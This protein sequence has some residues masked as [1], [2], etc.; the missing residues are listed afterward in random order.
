MS[1]TEQDFIRDFCPLCTIK[2][3]ENAI[4]CNLCGNN[5]LIPNPYPELDDKWLKREFDTI[6]E[7]DNVDFLL[8][9]EEEDLIIG[10]IP[11]QSGITKIEEAP[12]I[13]LDENAVQALMTKPFG[14]LT[15]NA[16]TGKT[17]LINELN[18]R[19]PT[20]FEICATTGIAA[21]NLNSKTLHS[22]LKFFD[23]KSLENAW[24]EQLLHMNLRK[25]RARRKNLLIDE[26]SMLGAEQLDLICNAIDDINQDGTGKQLGL[27]ISGDMCLA[28]GTLVMMAD[29][30]LKPIEDIKYN[31][32]VM[33]VDS[34]PRKVLA[35]CFGEDDLFL[36]KQTNADNYVVNSK[37]LISLRRGLDGQRKEE[38]KWLRYPKYGN[39]FHIPVKEL[40]QKSDK[41]REVFVGY[42]A[43]EI[44]MPERHLLIDPYFLGL[45][46]GD[47]DS[48]QPRITSEDI[49]I[50]LYLQEYATSLDMQITIGEW[51]RTNAVRIGIVRKNAP[52]NKLTIWLRS[53][54]LLHNKHIPDD[55]LYNSP[56]N[57]LL[58]LAGLIDS[59]G[60]WDSNRYR[61]ISTNKRLV[62]QVKQLADQLGFRVSIK[63]NGKDGEVKDSW[64]VYISGCTSKIPCRIHHKIS[65][66]KWHKHSELTSTLEIV[67]VN[68]G[69]YAGIMVDGD[70][71][72]LLAD[73]TVTHNC[74]LPPV[75]M[76]YVFKSDYWYQFEQNKV[77]L[78]KV[79]RQDNLEFME[80]INLLRANKGEE[81]MKIF[82]N[83]GVNFVDKMDDNFEGTT[84]IP[85]NNDVD[86]FNEKRLR[87]IEAPLIRSQSIIRGKEMNEW[88][89]LVPA[90][91]RLKIGAY[92]MILSNDVPN[93]SFV[94]GDCGWIEAYDEDDDAFLV[95]LKRNNLIVK[96]KRIKR[97]N[98]YDK[99]PEKYMYTPKF[100]PYQDFK[101]GDWVVGEISYHPLRLAYASTIHKSQG[102]SLDMVQINTRPQF[103]GY[104]AM[105]YVSISR[106]RTPE[107]L[108][109]V[110]NPVMIGRK[111]TMNKEVLKYV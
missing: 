13:Q 97:Q 104:D 67:P 93:F 87:M 33:G 38:N 28:T 29:G 27:W 102:L 78:T 70:N 85:N 36:I 11:L 68:R 39:K 106:A 14:F 10:A 58:L 47:G 30:K 65:D 8:S 74:Q 50:K 57:R 20:L 54:N 51:K 109:L 25:V 6:E 61:F 92:V 16:G 63:D 86:T 99:E 41:F 89:R 37:H 49:E 83:C 53:Y 75:K 2:V 66:C 107:G 40:M 64:T 82:Q 34:T 4:S 5:D 91:L 26:G 105:G 44:K 21:V 77:R 23:T 81:A 22:T 111:I 15:G 18:R 94:N 69:T 3:P 42:K 101:T 31:D 108:Y 12:P 103:F 59:D 24:R 96:I 32:E 76:K 52:D 79:W 35:T 73:G 7:A 1:Q 17:T 56:K 71:L 80:G 72:F 62:H 100:S 88:S 43:G 90:E 45:W 55:Y 84:L 60:S 110:G 46:L 98:F 48:D 95:K 9:P 19:E